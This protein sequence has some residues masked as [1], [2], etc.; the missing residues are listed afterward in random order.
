MSFLIKLSVPYFEVDFLLGLGRDI[1]VQKPIISP[2]LLPFQ[3]KM[4]PY[5]PPSLEGY[6]ED[7]VPS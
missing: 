6:P 7:G 3:L 5:H 4:R 2:V 1:V